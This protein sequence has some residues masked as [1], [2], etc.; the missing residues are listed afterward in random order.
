MTHAA[1]DADARRAAGISDKLVRLSVGIEAAEDLC[2]DL[3][4]ALDEAV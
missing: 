1:M 3:N 2:A 4:A